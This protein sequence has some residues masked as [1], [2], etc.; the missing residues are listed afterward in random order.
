MRVNDKIVNVSNI[1]YIHVTDQTVC[2]LEGDMLQLTRGE[3]AQLIQ[4]FE[5]RRELINLNKSKRLEDIS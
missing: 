5:C 4:V 1:A 2:F 3:L